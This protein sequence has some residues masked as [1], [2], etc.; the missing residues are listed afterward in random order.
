ML[1]VEVDVVCAVQRLGDYL[2]DLRLAGADWPDDG[3]RFL[4]SHVLDDTE[5]VIELLWALRELHALRHFVEGVL[6]RRC[7]AHL[8][9]LPLGSEGQ[10]S[11]LGVGESPLRGSPSLLSGL[12]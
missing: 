10:V 7:E 9:G 1:E 11:R 4:S 12:S 3:H 2:E 8:V 6:D 5:A